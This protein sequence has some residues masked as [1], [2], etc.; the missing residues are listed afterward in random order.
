MA[1]LNIIEDAKT[2]EKMLQISRKHYLQ[3][4]CISTECVLTKRGSKIK[5][6]HFKMA[7]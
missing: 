1:I 2:N 7:D 3:I 6:K 4:A 5:K